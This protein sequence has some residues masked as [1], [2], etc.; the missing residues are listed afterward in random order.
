[1][2]EDFAMVKYDLL[3]VVF[4]A[5]EQKMKD[6]VSDISELEERI[7]AVMEE[8]D[9]ITELFSATSEK[10]AHEQYLRGKTEFKLERVSSQLTETKQVCVSVLIYGAM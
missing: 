10:L 6:Q 3:M 4:S 5:I 7:K 8:K 2:Y 9:K 1:L